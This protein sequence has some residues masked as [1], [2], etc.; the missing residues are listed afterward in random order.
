M[1][2]LQEALTEFYQDL[3]ILRTQEAKFAGNAPLDLLAKIR[4]NETAIGLIQDALAKD[5]LSE[6]EFK[7]LIDSLRPLL[8]RS[9]IVNQIGA[10]QLER[11]IPPQA[12]EPKTILVPGGIFL[13]GSEPGDGIPLTETKQHEVEL[14]D[15][16]IGIYPVTNTEYAEFIKQNKNHQPPKKVGWLGR[17]PRGKLD[18]QVV[19]VSWYDAA[20]YCRWLSE[21]T[22]RSYRLPTEA[23]WERASRGDDGWLFPWGNDWQADNCNTGSETTAVT[24]YPQG[25]SPYGCF[26]MAGNILEWTQTVWGIHPQNPEFSYP[27]NLNDGREDLEEPKWRVLRGGSF[28]DKP[29]QLRASARFGYPPDGMIKRLGFRVVLEL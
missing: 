16:R 26:D 5:G 6:A 20:A 3:R 27:Y 9:N 23:E 24:A 28:D 8:L 13:M 21:K 22:N 12:F 7:K 15:Y 25:R 18:H 1:T 2:T 14:A 11:P 4:D 17:Q 29:T 10:D 19:M